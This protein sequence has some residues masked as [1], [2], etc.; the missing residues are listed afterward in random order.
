[1]DS[2]PLKFGFQQCHL[3]Y[4]KCYFPT[5]KTGIM[6][7]LEDL[8]WGLELIFVKPSAQCLAIPC[9]YVS[10]IKDQCSPASHGFKFN[11]LKK[12]RNQNWHTFSTLSDF[13]RFKAFRT[14]RTAKKVKRRKDRETEL[15]VREF[16][17]CLLRSKTRP[18]LPDH[19]CDYTHSWIHGSVSLSKTNP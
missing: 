15:F 3:L 2:A 1:M 17:A 8:L 12:Q 13:I 9:V 16:Q 11:A 6:I 7:F 5:F 14:W 10:I 18:W 4:H 19:L